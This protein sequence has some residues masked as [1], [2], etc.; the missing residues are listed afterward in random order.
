MDKEYH[1][2]KNVIFTNYMLGAMIIIIEVH[3]SHLMMSLFVNVGKEVNFRMKRGDGFVNVV[4]SSYPQCIL[5][6]SRNPQ[7]GD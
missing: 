3:M 4:G 7:H 2:M 1:I 6:P 5:C